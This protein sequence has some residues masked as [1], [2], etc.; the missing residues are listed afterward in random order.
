MDQKREAELDRLLD[1]VIALNDKRNA[2]AH[3]RWGC[4][5]RDGAVISRHRYW[6]DKDRG[7]D[8]AQLMKLRDDIRALRDRLGR[9]PW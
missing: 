8:E 5:K 2:I 3:G 7:T 1:K 6:K 4:K 9:Y